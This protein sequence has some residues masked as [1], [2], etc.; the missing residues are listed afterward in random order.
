MTPTP[1][2][3]RCAGEGVGI[4]ARG[5][6]PSRLSSGAVAGGKW[7]VARGRSLVTFTHHSWTSRSAYFVRGSLPLVSRLPLPC[8]LDW[9]DI[10]RGA[11]DHGEMVETLDYAGRTRRPRRVLKTFEVAIIYF[12]LG[13]VSGV[14]SWKMWESGVVLMVSHCFVVTGIVLAFCDTAP[15]GA[16]FRRWMLVPLVLVYL[17]TVAGWSECRHN[18]RLW[19]GLVSITVR[20]YDP[21]PCGYVQ[22]VRHPIFRQA[23]ARRW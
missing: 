19:F 18:D 14:A 7:L 10:A 1:A 20:E 8:R 21:E 13:I 6:L 22:T 5:G 11:V 16:A 2:L 17:F 12:V 4:T 3:P 9:L 15:G 23:E